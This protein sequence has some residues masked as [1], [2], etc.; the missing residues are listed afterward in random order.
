MRQYGSSLGRYDRRQAE[1]LGRQPGRIPLVRAVHGQGAPMNAPSA[2]IERRPWVASCSSPGLRWISTSVLS[3]SDTT[4]TLAFRP[5]RETPTD[6]EPPFPTPRPRTGGPS[7]SWSPWRAP[8]PLDD[9]LLL[10]CREQAPCRAVPGPAVE[11]LAEVTHVFSQ[12]GVS[13]SGW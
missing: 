13:V 6:R 11:P 5:P 1:R 8:G 4:R 3:L 10:Q 9:P 2:A 12:V 7:R